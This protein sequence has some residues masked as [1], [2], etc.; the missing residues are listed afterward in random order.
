MKMAE[1]RIFRIEGEINKPGYHATF[2]K[3]FRALTEEDARE[4]TYSVLGGG[5]QAKRFQITIKQIKEIE[6]DEATDP[7]VRALSGV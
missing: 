6:P 4:K 1:V 2:T 5:E 7:V 3:E